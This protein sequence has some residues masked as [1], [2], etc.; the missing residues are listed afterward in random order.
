MNQLFPVYLKLNRLPILVVGGG[1]IAMEKVQTLMRNSPDARITI[2]APTIHPSIVAYTFGNR[3]IKLVFKPFH[4]DAFK[5]KSLVIAATRNRTLNVEIARNAKAAGLPVNAADMPD[6]CD[7]YLASIVKKG[8][9]K[10][11][12]STNGKSPILARRIREY[13]EANLP[14]DVDSLV[15]GLH[16][17]RPQL[18]TDLKERLEQLEQ[19]TADLVKAG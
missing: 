4:P 9:L 8:D 15:N 2:M 11:A 17:L 7:F 12:I 1:E 18:G 14:D 3:R 13:L 10:V 19:L 16:D 5:G 6:L